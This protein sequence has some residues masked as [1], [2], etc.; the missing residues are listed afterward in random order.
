MKDNKNDLLQ[1]TKWLELNGYINN[2]T[3]LYK[4]VEKYLA[5]SVNDNHGFS[6]NIVNTIIRLNE[7]Y[8]KRIIFC[9]S[10]GLVLNG[11]ISR[12]IHDIDCFTLDNHYGTQPLNDTEHNF[13]SGH[14]MVSN[15]E[16]FR[17]SEKINN[18]NIDIMYRDDPENIKYSIVDFHG[19]QIK[20][21]LPASA[22]QAK[23]QYLES[24]KN[25]IN[26]EKHLSDLN[27]IKASLGF[28]DDNTDANN[29]KDEYDFLPL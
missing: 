14:F 16:I 20:V 3:N 10:F 15:K 28:N 9:G 6:E 12:E 4:I 11:L 1:Y 8:D 25:H 29:K 24:N 26:K 19:I 27:E 2:I 17:F 7:K 5:Y 21:E 22:I 23:K 13:G 18:I